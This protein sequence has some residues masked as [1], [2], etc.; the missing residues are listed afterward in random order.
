MIVAIPD[1]YY[2][3]GTISGGGISEDARNNT[4][5]SVGTHTIYLKFAA[6]DF[7]AMSADT[8]TL[9]NLYIRHDTT[10][11]YLI[12][13]ANPSVSI[14]SYAPTDF[15]TPPLELT[16]RFWG[17]GH[18]TDGD[19]LY[20]FYRFVIEVNKLRIEEGSFY[21]YPDI[22]KP[23]SDHIDQATSN[24]IN[25]DS[26]GLIN[27]TVD[28][29]GIDIYKSGIASDNFIVK[30]IDGYFNHH[31]DI[32]YNWNDW[33]SFSDEFTTSDTYDFTEFEGPGAWLTHNFNDYGSD[34]DGD[35]LF[36]FIVVEIEV[37]VV[38]EGD[39]YLA[40]WLE[41]SSTGR[42]I[43]H[44]SINV[45]LTVGT[46]T[47]SLQYDG[48]D[49]WREAVNDFV[50]FDRLRL[51]GGSPQTELD[52]NTT[53]LSH[54]LF[55]DFDPPKA[56]FT[57]IYSDTPEDTNSDGL[58]DELR[59]VLTFP[60]SWIW[61]QH[62]ITTYLLD[63]VYIYEVDTSN[64]VIKQWD[65][66]D[67]PFTT[68]VVYDSDEFN[69][70]PVIFT[71][72]FTEGLADLDSDGLTDYFILGVEIEVTQTINFDI[73][74]YGYLYIE[75][76]SWHNDEYSYDLGVGTHWIELG[77][78]T[79][80]LYQ[81]L[82]DQ[83]YEIDLYLERTDTWD[84]LDSYLDYETTNYAYTAFDPPGAEFTGIF[85][86]YGV[87]TDISGDPRFDYF[88]LAFEVNVI[89]EGWYRIYG[90]LYADEGG[91][92]YYLYNYE[93]TVNLS[94][95]LYNLTCKVDSYWFF[96]HSS[97]ASV[98]VDYIYLYQWFD[99]Y[100]DAR[101]GYD[102]DNRYLSRTYYH[103]EFDPPPIAFSENGFFDYGEDTDSNGRF[104]HITV[105][106]ELNVTEAGTYY[107][108]GRIYCVTGG[109]SFYF[110]SDYMELSVGLHNYTFQIEPT[111]VRNHQDGS[112]FYINYMYLYQYIPS[113][114]D[115]QRGY[116]GV[117]QYFSRIYYHNDFDPPDAW[118]MNVLE[119][120]PMDF[121]SDGLYDVYR[122]VY[123]VNVTVSSLDLNIYTQLA[124][125]NT[126]N[127]ITSTSLDI[128]D[129]T[130]G[131]HNISIDFRGDELYS[132]GFTNGLQISRYELWRIS[133][134]TLVD[135]FSGTTPLTILYTYV[136]FNPEYF[137]LIRIYDIS[138]TENQFDQ[139]EINV[140]ILRY[141]SEAVDQVR[142]EAEFNW[143]YM[144]R[145]YMG[146]NFEIWTY[147]YSPSSID[148][149]FFIVY[150]SGNWGSE[151]SMV[152][153]TGGPAFIL[154]QVNTTHGSV[155]NGFL[156]SARVN[157]TDGIDDVVLHLEGT[158]YPMTFISSEPDYDLWQVSVQITQEGELTAYATATDLIGASSDSYEITLYMEAG[159]PEIRSF[160][161]NTTLPI[162]LGG[163]I[164]FEAKYG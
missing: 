87:D 118:V 14:G 105:E 161:M 19:A 2:F 9:T 6:W 102:G 95:G 120:Y 39:Y 142:V 153:Q 38:I 53:V 50:K 3:S 26:T 78:F 113:E 116:T 154:F 162:T 8:I 58:W 128:Y 25:L 75:G 109:D 1:T 33:F 73:R 104:D 27:V 45:H 28:F 137:P 31:E 41:I 11:Q 35:S 69:A 48:L 155:G 158:D 71:G 84:R 91:D 30:S 101:A 83:T 66:R 94:P 18:D 145:I 88:E 140:T 81:T 24:T 122:V 127:F 20:N 135:E 76:E 149:Y 72:V 68:D 23:P 110:G 93:G 51:E 90:Y 152:Y 43:D 159:R 125:Q 52:Y 136:D 21:L 34:T 13:S 144:S 111:W 32:G 148:T 42:N 106:I 119:F 112:E 108:N 126:N 63:Y 132:S 82:E 10:P 77:W 79:V 150:A 36:N 139:V 12:Y 133:D 57:G 15:D 59:I 61:S 92:S 100:G 60:G 22:Y 70:P 129:L 160:T 107:I 147:T 96:S 141:S 67:D 130:F 54:Y 47:V 156:F 123:E 89:E 5:L 157:D 49:V 143:Y 29:N 103:S 138:V 115:V 65:Y 146:G 164:H 134:W 46:H 16:G 131:M 80:Q 117:T 97:G 17:E 124:E 99:G 74:L 114:G 37:E 44:T 7:Q 56:R 151:D 4:Y 55:T 163:A 62:T 86:D 85:Y 121:N 98:Y 40:S 64:N